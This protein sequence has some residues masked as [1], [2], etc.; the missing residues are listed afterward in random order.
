MKFVNPKRIPNKIAIGV[1]Y[2]NNENIIALPTTR[3]LL[4]DAKYLNKS[5][6]YK[7]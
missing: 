6:K 4:N 2:N 7:Y 3:T 5:K 1:N